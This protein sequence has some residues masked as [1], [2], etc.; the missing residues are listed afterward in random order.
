MTFT[1]PALSRPATES[2]GAPIARSAMPS[3]SK[4]AVAFGDALAVAGRTSVVKAVARIRR[5]HVMAGALARAPMQTFGV[6]SAR[7]IRCRPVT[8][9]DVVVT[10][11][12]SA[13]RGWQA[14][15]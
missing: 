14:V 2:S 10:R 15:G 8:A 1:A 7:T 9:S 4:S 11:L 6:V 5:R 13:I 3:P 12:T